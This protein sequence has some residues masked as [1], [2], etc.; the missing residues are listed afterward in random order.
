MTETVLQEARKKLIFALDVADQ[1]SALDLVEKLRDEVGLFKV[2]LE[3]YLAQGPAVMQDLVNAALPAGIFLDLK[4]YDIPATV[5]GALSTIIHGVSLIT[6]PSDLGPTGLKIIVDAAGSATILAVTVLTS[7][8]AQDLHALGYDPKYAQ[9]P[10][11]L[12]LLRAK[13]AQEA[14]CAGVVCS[15]REAA[16]VRQAC[17]PEF[18]IVCPGIR[19]AW[20]KVSGDDQQRVVTPG[21]AIK[22]GADYVVVGRPLRQA[23]N[24]AAAARRVV[25]EIA[26]ALRK[27][28]E[29]KDLEMELFRLYQ[30]WGALGYWAKRF[31]Q[32]FSSHCKRYK[33]GVSAVRTVLYKNQ[34]DGF[35]FLREKDRMDLSIEILV[36]KPEWHKLFKDKDRH[37]AKMKLGQKTF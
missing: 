22:N 19:P 7:T 8:T 11:A 32:M 37:M 23:D 1:K 4:L 36:L 20:A 27:G 5:L 17:G 30:Q 12:V 6:L 13:L 15:G 31:F 3:L 18:L 29:E 10:T 25:E 24:P 34:T 33:G 2:G 28:Y 21:E 9:D 26:A 35:S 16:A 14:G